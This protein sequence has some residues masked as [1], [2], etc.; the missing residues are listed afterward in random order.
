[1]SDQRLVFF[2][3]ETSGT[4]PREHTI[5]QF[6]A[7]A[8]DADTLAEIN[9]YECK[10]KFKP[11][12]ADPKALAV[13]HYDPN[14]WE[15]SAVSVRDAIAGIQSYFEEHATLARVSKAGNPY[16]V[17]QGVAHNASFD[18]EFLKTWFTR[19]AEALN[20]NRRESFLPCEPRVLCTLQLAFWT[21]HL[22]PELPKPENFKLGTLCKHLGCPIPEGDAHDALNDCR[23]AVRL[24]GA[25]RHIHGNAGGAK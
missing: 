25:F 4:D 23:A 2:V 13:N 20:L 22:R 1:M 9:A 6:A 24:L 17:A 7:V 8:V 21:Y 16:R 19:A 14:V 18:G 12:K 3:L 10:I 11:E 5:I 15:S